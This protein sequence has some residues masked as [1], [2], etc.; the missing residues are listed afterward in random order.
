M[1]RVIRREE[2]F[3]LEHFLFCWFC[4]FRNST[5]FFVMRVRD[6]SDFF[7][8]GVY[9]ICWGIAGARKGRVALPKVFCFEHVRNALLSYF[10]H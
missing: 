4:Y 1:E 3:A 5:V 8:M 9:C 2:V 7:G 6:K 10:G